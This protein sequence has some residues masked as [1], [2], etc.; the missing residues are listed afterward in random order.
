MTD[1]QHLAKMDAEGQCVYNCPSV[2]YLNVR[3]GRVL[4][5]RYI[6]S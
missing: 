6:D 5:S 2:T 1:R 3:L 4:L